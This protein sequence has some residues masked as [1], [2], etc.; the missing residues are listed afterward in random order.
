MCKYH[1]LWKFITKSGEPSIKLSLVDI[2]RIAG[3]TL[4]H[5]FLNCKKELLQFGY[6]AKKTLKNKTVV[7][8]K[9]N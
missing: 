6:E 7:F 3:I 5:S 4:D 2:E 8:Q 9:L 1:F